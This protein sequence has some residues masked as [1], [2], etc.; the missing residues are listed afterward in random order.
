[1]VPVYTVPVSSSGKCRKSPTPLSSTRLL[2]PRTHP[3]YRVLQS[4]PELH[5]ETI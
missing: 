3:S 1:M 2:T 5:M 4:L